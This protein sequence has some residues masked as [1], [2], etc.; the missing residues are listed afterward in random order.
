MPRK[1][2]GPS[3]KAGG[4]A[5]P[6]LIRY[7]DNSSETYSHERLKQKTGTLTAYAKVGV[8]KKAKRTPMPLPN[9]RKR[10]GGA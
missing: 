5:S 1:R 3:G 10:K 7:E 9:M 6:L 2:K 8:D 4:K